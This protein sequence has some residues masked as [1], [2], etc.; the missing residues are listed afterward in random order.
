[1]SNWQ[2]KGWVR[3]YRNIEDWPLYFSEP[4]TKTQA[5][6]DLFLMA[7]HQPGRVYIRGVEIKL[8]RGQIAWSEV[9]MAARWRWG[10]NKVRNFLKWLK[11]EQ[12]IEQQKSQYL[13]SIIT[14]LNYEN[15]QNDTADDT[16]EGQQ[17]IQQTEHKQECKELK[18]E[19][20]NTLIIP[21]NFLPFWEQ[22]RNKKGKQKAIQAWNRMTEQEQKL[23]LDALPAHNKQE[24]WIRDDG[25][26]IPH[27]ATWLNGKRWLDEL[28]PAKDKFVVPDLKKQEDEF[29]RRHPELKK[30]NI[31]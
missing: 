15:F 30:S 10:R 6:I 25:R 29:F 9:T 5:W 24:Q 18:N 12:Q 8:K 23:A 17:T 14:I 20:N 27:P 19:K 13:T 21:D 16:A 4:F 31:S 28:V 1:M 3:L 2:N 22:Y 11:T 26:Y 7:N